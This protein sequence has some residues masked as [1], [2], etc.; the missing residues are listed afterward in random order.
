VHYDSL[1]NDDHARFTRPDV[2]VATKQGK[3]SN[4]PI[5]TLTPLAAML[6]LSIAASHED[7]DF[8]TLATHVLTHDKFTDKIVMICWHHE[9]LPR[10]AQALGVRDPQPNPWEVPL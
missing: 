6:G 5:E 3:I 9:T 8:V 1:A 10:L 4:R 7:K 2:L